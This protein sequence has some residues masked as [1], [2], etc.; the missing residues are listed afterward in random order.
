MTLGGMMKHL[1]L[2]EDYWFTRW[3]GGDDWPDVWDAAVLEIDDWEWR[4]ASEDAPARRFTL[5]QDAVARSRE[6]VAAS[7]TGAGLEQLARR[8]WP[9]GRAPSLGGSSAT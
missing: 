8:R 7:L 2:V 5:R 6:V 1:A 9:D 4:S 3:L